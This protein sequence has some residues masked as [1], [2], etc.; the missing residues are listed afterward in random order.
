MWFILDVFFDENADFQVRSVN[1]DQQR[2]EKI[3]KGKNERERGTV[4]LCEC[5]GK[6]G[7]MMLAWR[8]QK[9]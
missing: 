9:R 3:L 2:K 4:Q 1:A 6:A 5:G 8:L 7:L